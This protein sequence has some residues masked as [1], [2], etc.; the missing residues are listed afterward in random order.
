MMQFL[1]KFKVIITLILS[2]AALGTVIAGVDARYAKQDSVA[3]IEQQVS[4]V[5]TRLD[6]KILQDRHSA[7]QERVWKH[8]DRYIDKPMPE[9]VRD[10]VRALKK[11]MVELEKKMDRLAAK[12]KDVE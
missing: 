10:A 1:D 2:L 3:N 5:E 6:Y 4:K 9:S 12:E 11:E 8:E 7:L